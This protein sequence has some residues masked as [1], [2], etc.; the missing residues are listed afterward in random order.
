MKLGEWIA[1]Q[2]LLILLIGILL[3][4]PSVIGIVKT[5]VNYDLLSYLPDTLE[6]VKTM[7]A[8]AFVPSHAACSEDVTELAQYNIDKVFEIADK[9]TEICREPL[10]FESIL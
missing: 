5:R 8:R 9:I 4:I 1:K 6:T 2:R 3:P 10:C 7:K